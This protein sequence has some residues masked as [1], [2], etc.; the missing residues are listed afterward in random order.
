MEINK[1]VWKEISDILKK[2]KIPYTSNYS[3]R[4]TPKTMKQQ[5]LKVVDKNIQI[6]LTVLDYLGAD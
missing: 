4:D 6:N 5:D 3:S 1:E 2:H